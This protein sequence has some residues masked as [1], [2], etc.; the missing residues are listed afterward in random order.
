MEKI[1]QTDEPHLVKNMT[2]GVVLNNDVEG[3]KSY[4]IMREANESKRRQ[5]MTIE[6]EVDNIKEDITEIK[7]LLKYLIEKK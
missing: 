5:M 7:N 2:T 6:Q 3:Y 1:V 4:L